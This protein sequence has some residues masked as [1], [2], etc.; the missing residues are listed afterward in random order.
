MVGRVLRP[1]PSKPAKAL[2]LAMSAPPEEGLV[3]IADLAGDEASVEVRDG[4][5]LGEA[6][7]RAHQETKAFGGR[8]A[9]L[10]LNARQLDLFARSGLRWLPID[11]GFALPLKRG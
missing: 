11:S 9:A 2:V 1:H 8:R 10:Q 4:E 5:S 6:A 3:T 7:I